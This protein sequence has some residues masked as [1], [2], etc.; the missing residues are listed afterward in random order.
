MISPC[1][2]S[3]RRMSG[4]RTP[5]SEMLKVLVISRHYLRPGAMTGAVVHR[6]CVALTR[7]GHD[8]SVVCPIPRFTRNWRT[9]GKPMKG[10]LGPVLI[11]GVSVVYL[12]Y[13][14]VPNRLSAGLEVV[15]LRRSLFRFIAD[16]KVTPEYDVVHA[17]FLFPTA[18]ASLA[19]AKKLGLPLLVTTH[20]SDTHTNPRRNSGIARCTRKAIAASD[21]VIAVSQQLAGEVLELAQPREPVRVVHNGVDLDLFRPCTDQQALRRRRRLPIDGV[22]MCT[23]GRLVADKGIRELMSAFSGLAR[24]HPTVWLVVVGDGPSKRELEGWVRREGFEGRVFVVG[25]RPQEQMVRVRLAVGPGLVDEDPGTL[26][27]IL[28]F[29]DHQL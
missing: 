25:S 17:H 4:G 14:N 1:G 23:V 15:S 13:Y 22:G 3:D 27:E 20:G 6:Q 2:V 29:G 9:L 16:H 7:M 8:V 5:R 10:D 28:A 26:R 12:P 18:A 21:G 19:V 11:D 24:R